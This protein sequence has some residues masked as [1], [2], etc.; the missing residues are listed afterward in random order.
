ML[1]NKVALLPLV[2]DIGTVKSQFIL[3]NTLQQCS[4]K[5]VEHLCIDLLGVATIDTMMAQEIF[6]LVKA[7]RLIGVQTTLSGI[8]P[9]I[10][11]TAI[12]LGL[13]FEHV[14]TTS[15]LAQAL[16]SIS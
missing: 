5:D 1:Q 3:E 11:Q 15:S 7:L 16:N 13:S 12:R 10:S 14:K 9:E 6:N 8:R 2:G 4:E